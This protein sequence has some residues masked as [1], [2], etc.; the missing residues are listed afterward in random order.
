[1]RVF[2]DFDG[3]VSREDVVDTILETYADPAWL[4]VEQDWQAGRIGS[5][6]CLRAQ[7]ALVRATEDEMNGLLDRIQLDDGFAGLL[8]MCVRDAVAVHILSDG[9]D[10]CIGRILRR[11]GPDI[12]RLLGGVEVCASHLEPCGDRDW[13]VD[14]PLFPNMCA[15]GCATCKPAAMR[16]LDADDRGPTVFVGD[17]LS[18]RYAASAADEVF[19]KGTLAR[20]CR[21]EGIA[22]RHYKD[23]RDVTISLEKML[24]DRAIQLSP[25]R[26]TRGTLWAR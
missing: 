2:L 11:A 15:H 22:Y 4:R 9:F 18:D 14:F 5:R 13:R 21:R 16:L 1:M 19:A 25:E 26:I 6:E 12:E 17:G 10:Y 24:R 23:L 20:Y 8:E 3:T 7:M